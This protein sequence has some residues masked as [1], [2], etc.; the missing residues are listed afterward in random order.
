[1]KARLSRPHQ[2]STAGQGPYP[3]AAVSEPAPG[4]TVAA[5]FSG[6]P[7]TRATPPGQ[8]GSLSLPTSTV[9]SAARRSAS[10]VNGTGNRKSQAGA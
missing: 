5:I 1:M 2:S 7:Y 10:T 9:P 6:A 8:Y 3:D 4:I